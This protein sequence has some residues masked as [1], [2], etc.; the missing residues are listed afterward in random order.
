[1][2]IAKHIKYWAAFV[3]G[4]VILGSLVALFFFQSVASSVNKKSRCKILRDRYT[5]SGVYSV[6]EK[7][8][9]DKSLYSVHYNLITKKAT[10]ECMCPK[11]DILNKFYFHVR[12]LFNNKN[13]ETTLD[14]S[15]DDDY[16][17]S[18]NITKPYERNFDGYPELV[19]YMRDKNNSQF[20]YKPAS[21]SF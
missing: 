12:D 15:C 13:R 1:M 8:S 11:G 5:G 10:T 6:E 9:D 17:N 14:C 7:A 2:D 4:I 3:L 19:N 18:I 16:A 21:M 20:F